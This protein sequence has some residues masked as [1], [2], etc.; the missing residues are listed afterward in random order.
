[1]RLLG[2]LS[3][4]DP[5]LFHILPDSANLRSCRCVRPFPCV[6][7]LSRPRYA[8]PVILPPISFTNTFE[9]L[10][11]I[12]CPFIPSPVPPFNA[13]SPPFPSSRIALLFSSLQQQVILTFN[14][15]CASSLRVLCITFYSNSS[16]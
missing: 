5:A 11:R 6:L 12:P 16:L 13:P 4:P 9:L 15:P 7:C 10:S 8:H 2:Y 3:F 14:N 1:M